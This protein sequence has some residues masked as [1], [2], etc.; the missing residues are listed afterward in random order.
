MKRTLFLL[1]LIAFKQSTAQ[2]VITIQRGSQAF[3][4]TRLDTAVAHAQSNDYIYLPGG[5]ISGS[6]DVQVDKKLFIIGAGYHPDSSVATSTTKISGNIMLKAGS[7]GSLV[8]GIFSSGHIYIYSSNV[9]VTRSNFLSIFFANAQSNVLIEENIFRLYFFG[10]A[11]PLSNI[12][13]R[14]NIF[15]GV[16]IRDINGGVTFSNNVFLTGNGF[17][18]IRNCVFENNAILVTPGLNTS[19]GL[20]FF[21]NM[22]SN[23]PNVTGSGNIFNEPDAN[24]FVNY[25]AGAP[26]TP[27]H[28]FHLKPVS[29]GIAAGTDGKDI[30]LYGSAAP[31]KDGALPFNPHFKKALIPNA[32]AADGKL[33]VNITVQAQAN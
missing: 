32:T 19:S 29:H 31:F 6:A 8:T 28:N 26:W 23:T 18:N 30:G 16:T 27:A 17:D 5:L 22:F 2:N 14:K 24:Y 12:L 9:Q 3:L 15:Y 11:E 25:V 10:S 7:D 20:Q 1:L 4:E 33:N 21:N 13:V